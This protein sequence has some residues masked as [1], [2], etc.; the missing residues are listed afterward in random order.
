M[1]DQTDYKAKYLALKKR[2]DA[3]EQ[4]YLDVTHDDLEPCDACK[5]YKWEECWCKY[6]CESS[7]IGPTYHPPNMKYC[8]ACKPD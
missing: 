6:M 5:E 2:F 8:D 3:L 7:E 1:S 4:K